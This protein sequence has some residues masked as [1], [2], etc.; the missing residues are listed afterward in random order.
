MGTGRQFNPTDYQRLRTGDGLRF[1]EHTINAMVEM[2]EQGQLEQLGDADV[3][4]PELFYDGTRIQVYNGSGYDLPRFNIGGLDIPIFSPSQNLLEFQ[5][6]PRFNFTGPMFPEHDGRFCVAVEPIGN[7]KVGWAL[8][9]GVVAVK[10]YVTSGME[11]YDHADVTDGD[12]SQL[13]LLPS[14]AAH[15]LWRE[16]GAGAKWALVRLGSGPDNVSH[17]GVMYDQLTAGGSALVS[18][19]T[20]VPPAD[21]GNKIT[22]KD[23]YLNAGETLAVGTRVEVRW[24]PKSRQWYVMGAGCPPIV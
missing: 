11:W 10:V 15:V 6:Y 13:T 3:D 17:L 7:E 14:G 19:W 20:G 12:K 9:S 5:N 24:F 8:V 23:W 21:G 18:I 22:A 1:T 4:S 16:T 2:A